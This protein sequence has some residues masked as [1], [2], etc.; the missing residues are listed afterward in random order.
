MKRREFFK[1]SSSLASARLLSIPQRAWAS[2]SNGGDAANV[3]SI[4]CLPTIS[5]IGL[6]G[7]GSRMISRLTYETKGLP[8]NGTGGVSFFA[9]DP[10]SV[11][12]QFPECPNVVAASFASVVLLVAG[13]GGRIGGRMAKRLVQ[14]AK[15]AGSFSIA[16]VS[17]PLEDETGSAQQDLANLREVADRVIVIDPA[18]VWPGS[19][20]R[21]PEI[22]RARALLGVEQRLC[23][24]ITGLIKFMSNSQQKGSHFGELSFLLNRSG[25]AG[26]GAAGGG[27]RQ[28]VRDSVV[29]AFKQATSGMASGAHA[30]IRG[31]MVLFSGRQGIL[32]WAS[33]QRGKDEVFQQIGKQTPCLFAVRSDEDAGQFSLKTDVWLMFG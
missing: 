2:A 31:A 3:N 21:R 33:V 5:V 32:K 1:I 9:I 27:Y 28:D 25:L 26:F 30:E 14:Q 19:E 23:Q 17:M 16:A 7:F 13:L 11:I 20:T 22:G 15:H 4:E 18:E 24:C 29:A 6:G 10:D 12:S 8:E